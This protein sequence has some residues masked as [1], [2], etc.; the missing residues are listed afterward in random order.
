MYEIYKNMPYEN[1]IS[2]TSVDGKAV[3]TYIS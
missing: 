3:Y 1:F 2:M